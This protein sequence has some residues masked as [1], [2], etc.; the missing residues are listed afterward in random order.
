MDEQL[1]F[2]IDYKALMKEK[3]LDAYEENPLI[4]EK[5]LQLRSK[6]NLT[7]NYRFFNSSF[8]AGI[9]VSLCPPDITNLILLML[10]LNSDVDSVFQAIGLNFDPR[11]ELEKRAKERKLAQEAILVQDN[12]IIG[13][14]SED[15]AY[16]A[17]HE[18]L[19]EI[20]SQIRQQ[21]NSS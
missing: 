15:S 10:E 18:G 7:Q 17:A 1:N 2:D 6:G 11:Q 20:R 8:L 3:L 12:N 13:L 14:L 5:I 9:V 19:E 21:E 16:R 4:F